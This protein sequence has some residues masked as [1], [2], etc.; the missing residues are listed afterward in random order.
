MIAPGAGRT[1]WCA[2]RVPG[3]SPGKA[4]GLAP[5]GAFPH[6]IVGDLAIESM[7]NAGTTVTLVFPQRY[8]GRWRP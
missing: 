7:A 5:C 2:I 4:T 6:L 8:D 3:S 1:H